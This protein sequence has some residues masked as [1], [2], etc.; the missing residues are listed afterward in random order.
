MLSKSIAGLMIGGTVAVTFAA[1]LAAADDER[2][3]FPQ[4][5]R[6]KLVN[7]LSLDR[8]PPHDDQIIRLFSSSEALDA[9]QAGKEIPNGSILV[10]EVYKAKKDA[11]GK[12]IKSALG[13]RI[14]DKFAAIAV[15][16]KE[17]GW[18]EKYPDDLRNGDWDF[19]IFSPAGERL[20]DKDL[21]QCRTCHA[22]QKTT[23][24]IFSLEHMAK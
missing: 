6:T 17:K 9:V 15:M 19:A 21:N 4:D 11:D 14:R 22:P 13:Q 24:N 7:Y 16:K 3:A 23:Q 10:A 12:V 1:A 2:I 8:V 18:G 5:Y 20:K